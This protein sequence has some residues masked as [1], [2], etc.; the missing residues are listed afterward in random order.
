MGLTAEQQQRRKIRGV[1]IA[2]E[3]RL[4]GGMYR[5][6]VKH[7]IAT[8]EVSERTAKNWLAE[9]KE[10]LADVGEDPLTTRNYEDERM[11][12]AEAART[13]AKDLLRSA[14]SYRK[15][16]SVGEPAYIRLLA[17]ARQC[18]AQVAKLLHF[19]ITPPDRHLAQEDNRQKLIE[20]I[21]HTAHYFT[22]DEIAAVEFA[23]AEEK[24]RREYEDSIVRNDAAILTFEGL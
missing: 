12:L 20:L 2:K 21:I 4:A 24:A 5:D 17:E 3:L 1:E 13:R 8:C 16:G 15:T 10:Q 23:F 22:P 7:L 14:E 19:P 9:A 6:M 11:R 18:E